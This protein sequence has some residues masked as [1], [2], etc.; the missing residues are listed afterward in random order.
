MENIPST[1]KKLL[2][3]VSQLIL[4]GFSVL[5]KILKVYQSRNPGKVSFKDGIQ[6]GRQ[7]VSVIITM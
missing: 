5:F 1:V 3:K 2:Q 7:N 6:D 4:V